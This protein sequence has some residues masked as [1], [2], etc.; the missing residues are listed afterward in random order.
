[1]HEVESSQRGFIRIAFFFAMID[2]KGLP[3]ARVGDQATVG[4]KVGP[5]T[6]L[7]EGE[8]FLAACHERYRQAVG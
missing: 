3:P 5:R 6:W 7:P 1:M 4:F 8:D 2:M